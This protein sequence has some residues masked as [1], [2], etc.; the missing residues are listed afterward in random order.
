VSDQKGLYKGNDIYSICCLTESENP[1]NETLQKFAMIFGK[2]D[3]LKSTPTD[4]PNR[5]VASMLLVSLAL[6]RRCWWKC[7]ALGNFA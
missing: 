4:P 7:K 1:G 2:K 5:S 6:S 3:D